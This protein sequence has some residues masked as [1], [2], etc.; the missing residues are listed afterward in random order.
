MH[1]HSCCSCVSIRHFWIVSTQF[2]WKFFFN[3]LMICNRNMLC[4]AVLIYSLKCDF[5]LKLL[6][7]PNHRRDCESSS[8]F[9]GG[10]R[11]FKSK[12][13]QK[14]HFP[15]KG[16][17]E[18]KWLENEGVFYEAG[19]ILLH[20]IMWGHHWSMSSCHWGRVE[21]VWG[22]RS[23][24]VPLVHLSW[25]RTRFDFIIHHMNFHHGLPTLPFSTVFVYMYLKNN[26]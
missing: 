5:S 15:T 25:G 6:L 12:S 21:S 10:N 22:K 18:N 26:I 3:I 19:L 16:N 24:H 20:I 14:S 4:N 8:A 7:W 17:Q 1:D 23:V 9:T 11:Y 13:R 2:S